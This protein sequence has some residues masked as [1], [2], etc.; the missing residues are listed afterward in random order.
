VYRRIVVGTDGSESAERAVDVAGELA[1]LSGAQL[2]VVTAY[3]PART[4]VLA[5]V[6]ASGGAVLPSWLGDDER[7]AAEEVVR[8]ARRRMEG[9]GVS[10]HAV[11][12]QGEPADALLAVAEELDADLLVVGNRGMNGVRRYLLGAV[13][14]RVV[15]HAPCSVY[16]AHTAA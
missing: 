2:Q 5:G 16:V 6:G 8:R 10:V 12:R 1:R 13:A 11:A 3:Q 14:D 15:H 4:A 7:V 9:T